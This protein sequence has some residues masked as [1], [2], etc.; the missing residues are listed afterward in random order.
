MFSL[1]EQ[2]KT[3]NKNKNKTKTPHK[4]NLKEK[5]VDVVYRKEGREEGRDPN[6]NS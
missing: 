2:T 4:K 3:K 6:A 5:H 1:E